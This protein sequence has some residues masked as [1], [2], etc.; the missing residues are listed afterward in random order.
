MNPVL[1][2]ALAVH[3]KLLEL[4]ERFCMIGGIALQRWG[5]AR[6]TRDVDVTVLCAFGDEARIADRLLYHFAPR[7][8]NAHEF[9]IR[10]RVL[11]LKSEDNT[12]IDVALGA[13]PFEERCVARASDWPLGG[14][15]SLRTCSSEDLIVLKA[16]ASR[17]QDWVDITAVVTRQGK[18]LHW[19]QILE[20]IEPLAAAKEAP[21]IIERLQALR[22]TSS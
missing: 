9:A 17:P 15:T 5:E 22:R 13:I 8:A 11:L 20:E 2:T 21:D 14:D 4:G 19:P 7:L 18:K 16:F 1:G 3:R 12:P 10:N 6:L